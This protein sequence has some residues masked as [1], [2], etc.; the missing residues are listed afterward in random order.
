VTASDTNLKQMGVQAWW[1]VSVGFTVWMLTVVMPA[2]LMPILYVPIMDEMGWSRGQVTAFS[3]FKFGAGACVAFFMGH[4]IDRFGLNRVL[5]MSFAVV[6]LSIASLLFVSGLWLYYLAASMLG[7]AMLGS[8]TGI[9]VLISRWFSARLGFAIG[10]A[11]AGGG[12]AGIF[13]PPLTTLLNDLIGWRWTAVIMSSTVFLIL[14]PLYLWKARMTPAASEMSAEKIDPLRDSAARRPQ[15]SDDQPEFRE[16]LVMRSFWIVFVAHVLVGAVDHAM[17]D[18][19][20]LYIARDANLG[21]NVAA[22]G[23]TIVTVS[24]A[25][26]KIGF[27]WLF[28]RFSIRAVSLCWASMAVGIA[29]AF[30]VSGLFTF[31]VF[32]LARGASHGGV[33]VDVPI[34]AKHIFGLRSLSKTI[35]VFGAAN[36]LGGAIATGGVGFMHDAM[37]S[38]T[39]AFILLIILSLIAGGM[40]YW[41]E[42]RYWLRWR[43]RQVEAAARPSPQVP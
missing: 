4:I 22:W 3:S 11:L 32:T 2:S 39:V 8:I 26:G 9:K 21:L 10:L 24:G 38:Y 16:L 17:L 36:S 6:G 34:C 15:T 23:F 19:L 1:N 20:P 30:P 5:L 12:V 28:D 33:M 43:G 29:L 18:H 42:P 14:I 27:G 41:M 40:L 37:Q 13:V 7:V 25:L 35:A 31:A